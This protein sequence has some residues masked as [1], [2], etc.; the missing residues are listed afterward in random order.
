K[1][2]SAIVLGEGFDLRSKSVKF[3]LNEGVD[4]LTQDVN[5]ILHYLEKVKIMDNGGKGG[6]KNLEGKKR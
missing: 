2:L 5:S 3:Y 1:F 4:L 6:V